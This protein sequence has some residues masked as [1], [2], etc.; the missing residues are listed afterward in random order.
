MAYTT[1]KTGPLQQISLFFHFCSP[2]ITP[3]NTFHCNKIQ[4]ICSLW[5]DRLCHPYHPIVNMFGSIY[6][7]K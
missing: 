3:V 7:V 2:F 5:H 6:I 1:F 4:V